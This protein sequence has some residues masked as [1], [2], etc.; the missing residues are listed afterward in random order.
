MAEASRPM[1]MG[2]PTLPRRVWDK[3]DRSGECWSWT[4]CRNRGGYGQLRVEQGRT[5]LAHR[6]VY[7]RAVAAIPP[8]LVL[9]H[10]CGHPWCVNPAHLTPLTRGANVLCGTGP[11]AVNA[12]KTRC[13]RGHPFDDANTYYDP[14]GARRC[15]ACACAQS[16]GSR[17]RRAATARAACGHASAGGPV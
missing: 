16:A 1:T 2:A 7:E 15:R 9:H 5:A 14:T 13:K 6:F 17:R 11:T 3:I 12:R 8:G 4:A 10:E